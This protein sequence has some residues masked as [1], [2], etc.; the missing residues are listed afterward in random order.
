MLFKNYVTLTAVKWVES[1]ARLVQVGLQPTASLSFSTHSAQ[2]GPPSAIHRLT[3]RFSDPLIVFTF[4]HVERLDWTWELDQQ[5]WLIDLISHLTLRGLWD[6]L[7]GNNEAI[8]TTE[9]N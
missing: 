3:Y 1:F 4:G 9:Y 2:N 8:S 6:V 5:Y 7:T